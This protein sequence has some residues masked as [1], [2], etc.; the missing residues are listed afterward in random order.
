M[1]DSWPLAAA[2]RALVPTGLNDFDGQ[3]PDGAPLPRVVTNQSLPGVVT[4]SEAG[5]AH[6]RTGSVLLT[7]AGASEESVA[8]LWDRLYPAFEGARITVAGWSTSPL[9]MLE[10][11]LRI[12]PDWDAALTA[13]NTYPMVGK[14][15]FA[16]TVT[17][18]R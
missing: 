18:I 17:E 12:F 9:R 10:D 4:R 7:L 16:Y 2:V 11:E 1:T 6:A 8:W 14:A 15:T 3:A 13:T 5:T